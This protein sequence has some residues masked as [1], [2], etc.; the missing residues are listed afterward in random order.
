MGLFLKLHGFYASAAEGLRD[1]VK[2]RP[3]ADAYDQLGERMLFDGQPIADCIRLWKAG[4]KR[5]LP[6][7]TNFHVS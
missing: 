2:G 3:T 6:K 7:D 4:P 1:A 5:F